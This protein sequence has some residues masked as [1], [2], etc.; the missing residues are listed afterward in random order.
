MKIPFLNKYKQIL[1]NQNY[2]RLLENFFSL[3]GL[4]IAGYILPLITLPYLVRILGPE[5]YGLIAFATAF[6]TYFQLLT[7]YGF[8]L[9]ATREISIHRDDKDK[10]SE[11]FNS[12]IIIKIF[13]MF[14]SLLLLIIIVFSFNQFRNDWL[15]YF[16][17]FG[18]VIGNVLFP[19]WFFQG[20][21]K[22]KY[23]TVLNVLAQVIF[24]ISIFIFIRNPSDYIFVPLINSLGSII[25]GIL[26]FQI[27]LKDHGIKWTLPKLY[28]IKFHFKEGW[29]VFLST[30]AISLYTT[31]NTFI[32][33]LFTNNVIVSYYAVAEKIVI[34]VI[35][36]LNPISQ[37]IYPHISKV[38][39]ESKERGIKLIKQVTKIMGILGIILSL[40]LFLFADLIVNLIFGSQYHEATIVLRIIS[41]I[42]LVVSFSNVYGVL[43]LFGFGYPSKVSK[44]Q[45]PV[46]I[47]YLALLIPMTYFLKDIGTAFSFLIV[48]T[49]I[50]VLFWKL[51]RDIINELKLC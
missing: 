47:S 43:F 40:I 45:I 44:V 38:V 51:Y 28:I 22:M 13:L 27:A 49:V 5:K 21:E 23:I 19:V 3:S 36:L 4:Q 48:E 6:V 1:E 25:A 34:A 46:G 32:L 18:M 7:S 10:L 8:N 30:A 9:S 26:G 31:S 12:V 41:F 35:G 14:L 42:P 17:A 39:V 50:T 15:I 33:G 11:I 37:A 24:T 29:H 16:L 2:R 20:I